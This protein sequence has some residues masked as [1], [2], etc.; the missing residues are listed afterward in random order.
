MTIITIILIIIVVI[1]IHHHRHH[2]HHHCQ[3]PVS[4][5]AVERS[6]AL[7]CQMAAPAQARQMVRGFKA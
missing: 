3:H 1:I 5:E 6:P 7:T 4:P 2:H